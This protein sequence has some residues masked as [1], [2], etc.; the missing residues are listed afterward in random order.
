MATIDI[1]TGRGCSRAEKTAAEIVDGFLKRR[2][3]SSRRISERAGDGASPAIIIGTADSC[4]AIGRYLDETRLKPPRW[5]GYVIA[6]AGP[7]RI[8]LISS[9]PRGCVFGAH[10]LETSLNVPGRKLVLAKDRIVDEP[11]FEH[12]VMLNRLDGRHGPGMYAHVENYVR[13]RFNLIIQWPRPVL[14][15]EFFRKVVEKKGKSAFTGA[16][17]ASIADCRRTIDECRRF[18]LIPC[19]WYNEPSF[20]AELVKTFVK[21]HPQYKSVPIHNVGYDAICSATPG[22]WD[23]YREHLK[24]LMATFPGLGAMMVNT[25]E[26]GEIFCQC[27]NCRDYPLAQRIVDFATT[28]YETL[29]AIDPDFMLIIRLHNTGD[30]YWYNFHLDIKG[31]MESLPS[32]IIWEVKWCVPPCYD[33]SWRSP[34]SPHLTMPKVNKIT[35]LGYDFQWMLSPSSFFLTSCHGRLQHDIQALSQ[36]SDMRG[37][38]FHNNRRRMVQGANL[39]SEHLH[40]L[41]ARLSWDPTGI[42]PAR[43][44]QCWFQERFG[45]KAAKH[46]WNGLKDSES[47]AD[48]LQP[49]PYSIDPRRQIRPYSFYKRVCPHYSHMPDGRKIAESRSAVGWITGKPRLAARDLRKAIAC[50]DAEPEAVVMCRAFERALKVVRKNRFLVEEYLGA[51]EATLNYARLF[52]EYFSAYFYLQLSGAA[53]GAT[54]KKYRN[55]AFLSLLKGLAYKHL[56]SGEYDDTDMTEPW[57]TDF[58]YYYLDHINHEL[59]G[60]DWDDH[61]ATVRR[62]VS[63]GGRLIFTSD[64]I[65]E[66]DAYGHFLLGLFGLRERPG[67]RIELKPGT[68]LFLLNEKKIG[69]FSP[70]MWYHPV[71]IFVRKLGKGWVAYA[72]VEEWNVTQRIASA[73]MDIPSMKRKQKCAF[74]EVLKKAGLE[75]DRAPEMKYFTQFNGPLQWYGPL[76]NSG[77]GSET[78]RFYK[79]RP[80]LG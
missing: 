51:A 71:E 70:R 54:E 25:G 13:D 4:R 23:Y 8:Y 43:E 45:D 33:F 49:L 64:D 66:R 6:Q 55:Q 56:Y 26:L 7:G 14:P 77:P 2:G 40:P 10:R 22:F 79:L 12:R 46:I 37:I 27:N 31:I 9:S 76:Y 35:T 53:S 41:L 63:G 11:A 75:P 78:T 50:V 15:Y 80:Y 16:D 39:F 48:K 59:A 3:K 73:G 38:M 17:E 32:G 1:I 57:S 5:D 61:L 30:W 34:V 18:G 58:T 74:V 68:D 24:E 69:A 52:R 20:P 67:N 47:I 42:D 19:L 72:T 44:L 36:I 65:I 60:F 21:Q 62:F 29:T 28:S